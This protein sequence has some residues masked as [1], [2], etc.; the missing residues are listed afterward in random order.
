[1]T[2]RGR[3]PFP[4]VTVALVVAVL[5][6][7][8]LELANP[9]PLAFAERFGFVA[10]A[11]SFGT[12][13]SSLFVHD[14]NGW[15]HIGGNVAVLLVVGTLVE[16]SIGSVRFLSLFVAGGL[17]GAGLHLVIDPTSTVAL[18]GCSGSLFAI[19]AVAATL[20][21][22]GMLAFVVV[23]ITANV[24]HAFGAPGDAGV[25]FAAHLGGA[26]VGAAVV[27]LARLRGVE[28]RHAVTA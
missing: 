19:L 18:V 20:Y 10:A 23:L 17:F 3:K 14:P 24:A 8:G 27:V 1:M 21:G 13:L 9:D 12:A 25:S 16:R 28:L 7:F 26:F 5:A 6:A 15:T 22:P 4:L 11:P 2:R